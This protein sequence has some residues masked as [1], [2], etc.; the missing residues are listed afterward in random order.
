M[1]AKARRLRQ[2]RDIVRVYKKGRSGGAADLHVK[3]LKTGWPGTRVAIVVSKKVSK[4]AVVR[5]TIRR[6]VS[7]QIEELW[8][9]L[10]PGYDVVVTVRN[11]IAEAPAPVIKKQVNQALASSGALKDNKAHV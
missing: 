6:R 8:N 7:G 10:L 9:S 2:E 3:A 4:K 5:N 11:D 1:L